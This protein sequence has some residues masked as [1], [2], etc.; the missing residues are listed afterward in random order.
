M[1]LRLVIAEVISFDKRFRLPSGELHSLAIYCT[2]LYQKVNRN[3]EVPINRVCRTIP[4]IALS[5][6]QR[7]ARKRAGFSAWGEH[8]HI[9]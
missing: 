6:A 7:G 1:L 3:G 8:E 4:L 9:V 5:A 2:P